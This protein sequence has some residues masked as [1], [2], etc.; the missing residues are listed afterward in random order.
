MANGWS[1]S[2]RGRLG[3]NPNPGFWILG[4]GARL[5]ERSDPGV[6]HAD[7][8]ACNA[9]KCD[10]SQIARADAGDRRR[11]GSDDAG[12]QRQSGGSGHRRFARRYVGGC[13]HAMLFEQPNQV[14]DALIGSVAVKA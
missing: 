1:H 3:G 14:L 4:G 6:H 11:S 10:P 5:I 13:G 9:F 2:A 8:S 12:A 7:L